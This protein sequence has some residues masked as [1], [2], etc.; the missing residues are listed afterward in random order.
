M[1]ESGEWKR[2][3]FPRGENCTREKN[4]SLSFYSPFCCFT[5]SGELSPLLH[6]L[7]RWDKETQK[8][9]DPIF[10]LENPRRGYERGFQAV[11]MQWVQEEQDTRPWFYVPCGRAFYLHKLSLSWCAGFCASTNHPGSVNVVF[12]VQQSRGFF[13]PELGIPQLQLW[14]EAL[15]KWPNFN[16][17]FYEISG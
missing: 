3:G 9:N 12:P 10:Q 14:W 1:G 13:V 6:S 2:R 7:T 4:H 15:A 11:D 8:W 5:H 16:F 17:L